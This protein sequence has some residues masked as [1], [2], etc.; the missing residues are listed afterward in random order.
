MTNK[1]KI[2]F[3][4]LTLFTA[5]SIFSWVDYFNQGLASS[6]NIKDWANGF[7]LKTDNDPDK[8]GLNNLDESYWNTDFQNP[9]T[10]GDGFLDGEEVASGHDPTKPGPDDSLKD[11]NLTQKLSELT[12]AGLVEGSL[13]LSSPEL[14]KS[15]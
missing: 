7:S 2:F 10:D 3:G 13:K 8:D 12:S 5:V 4:I 1:I 15:L 11:I 6:F 14:E 9:D